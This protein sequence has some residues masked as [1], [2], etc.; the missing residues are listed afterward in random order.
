MSVYSETVWG[1]HT[2]SASALVTQH[3]ILHAIWCSNCES[4]IAVCD[5]IIDVEVALLPHTMAIKKWFRSTQ[6]SLPLIH[7]A[8]AAGNHSMHASVRGHYPRCVLIVL[9]PCVHWTGRMCS[10]QPDMLF[11]RSIGSDPLRNSSCIYH[12]HINIYNNNN[13]ISRKIRI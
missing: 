12:Q 7:T 9:M 13:S 5:V 8:A 4:A 1:A 2:T 3:R 11:G 6:C 10:I